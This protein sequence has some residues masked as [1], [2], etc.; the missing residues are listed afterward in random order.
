MPENALPRLRPYWP[1]PLLAGLLFALLAWGL[2]P[3]IGLNIGG[4]VPNSAGS[5][6]FPVLLVGVFLCS[7]LLW[8]LLLPN[9]SRVLPLAG[10][11]AGI[12]AAALSYFVVLGLHALIKADPSAT[13]GVQG[14]VWVAGL[15]LMTT[16]FAA[17]MILGLAG[18]L[19]AWALAAFVRPPA[20]RPDRPLR[21]GKTISRR[22]RWLAGIGAFVLVAALTGSFAFL[23]LTPVPIAGLGN[24]P[25]PTAPAQSYEQAFAAFYRLRGAEGELALH[26]RCSSQLLTHGRKTT[27]AVV[28]FHGLTSCPSQGEGLARSVYALGY[29]V[30]LP[31]MFG[32]GEADPNTASLADLT[33]EH[34]VDLANSSVDLAQGLGDNVVVVGLSAGGTIVAWTAQH[35]ADVRLA[36]PVSPFLGPYIVPA[37]ANTAA[38]NLLLM[39]PNMMFWINPLAPVTAPETDYVFPRPS[40]HTLAQVMRLG[41]AVLYDA[42]RTPPAVGP[43]SVVLN[44]ADVAVNNQLTSQLVDLWRVHDPAVAV[45]TLDFANHL[46]HDLINPN[47]IFGDTDL[48]YSLLADMI[49]KAAP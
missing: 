23:S 29:N 43:I 7:W 38:T 39:L 35:R 21:S 8:W 17:A 40:T 47:E 22:L 18:A 15:G 31:R 49:A 37:W 33:A 9:W 34:L 28:F 20:A 16:G 13:G 41:E 11:A 19:L 10:A 36:V 14:V 46:P 2:G 25:S 48:V 6:P 27:M 24:R 12:L 4:A 1:W 42:A 3:V 32:H 5:V 44:E 26:P 45:E 30:F